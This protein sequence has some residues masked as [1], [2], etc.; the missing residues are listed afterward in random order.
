MNWY[1]ADIAK[2]TF[3]LVAVRRKARKSWVW[4]F[5]SGWLKTP[6][7]EERRATDMNA[8]YKKMALVS[9]RNTRV[10]F[11]SELVRKAADAAWH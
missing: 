6:R 8:S 4:R 2:F 11:L 3:M 5:L 10:Y 9:A 1:L 7:Y